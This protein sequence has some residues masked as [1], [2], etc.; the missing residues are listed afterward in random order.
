MI[1]KLFFI[2][3]K[4]LFYV[5]PIEK[6]FRLLI[7][8]FSIIKDLRFFSYFCIIFFISNIFIVKFCFENYIVKNSELCLVS[9]RI[10]IFEYGFIILWL[11]VYFCSSFFYY[12]ISIGF[13]I[14][15]FL[16]E[17]LSHGA[18]LV[19]YCIKNCFKC[20]SCS[21]IFQKQKKIVSIK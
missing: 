8:I 16:F 20:F 19:N 11:F 1:L 10:M 3:K 18:Y 12:T 13:S 21:Y 15:I 14:S 5:L 4:V 7:E 17:R 9:Y 6:L 2:L